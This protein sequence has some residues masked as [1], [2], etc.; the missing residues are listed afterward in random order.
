MDEYIHRF[1]W[2]LEQLTSGHHAVTRKAWI[3]KGRHLALQVPDALSKMTLPY[4]Y[5][6]T[7]GRYLQ[8]WSASQIDIL[9]G[10]WGLA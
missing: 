7:E 4:I 9:S 8:P 1:S 5:I 3:G 2:A 6:T 10:D